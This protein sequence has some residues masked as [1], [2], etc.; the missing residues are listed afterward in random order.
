MPDLYDLAEEQINVNLRGDG[1][2]ELNGLPQR[3]AGLLLSFTAWQALFCWPNPGHDSD[4]PMMRQMG[5]IAYCLSHDF[6]IQL[7]LPYCGLSNGAHFL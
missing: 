5:G 3:S 7:K 6:E 4:K 1:M 2:N